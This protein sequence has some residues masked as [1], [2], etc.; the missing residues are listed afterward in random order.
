MLT[1]KYLD[2]DRLAKHEH[3]ALFVRLMMVANDVSSGR[4]IRYQLS[5]K[6]SLATRE[7]DAGIDWYMFRLTFAHVHE[8]LKV[9]KS[10]RNTDYVKVLLEKDSAA[11][12]ALDRLFE[13]IETGLNPKETSFLQAIRDKTAF[14]YD[15]NWWKEVLSI[16]VTHGGKLGTVAI[17]AD[18]SFPVRWMPAD[19]ASA[20]AFQTHIFHTHKFAT[21]DE[22]AKTFNNL[23]GGFLG[24][25]LSDLNLVLSCIL[26]QVLEDFCYNSTT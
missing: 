14:H 8:A 11:K 10:A 20:T 2:L 3:A 15:Q 17:P 18:E 16:M 12:I 26:G 21:N 5:R 6:A 23:V 7:I 19:H 9:L 1:L 4:Y 13:N 25:I 24:E 22:E